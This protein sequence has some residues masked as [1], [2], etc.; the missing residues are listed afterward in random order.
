MVHSLREAGHAATV[1][2]T[3]HAALLGAR[4]CP[5]LILLDLGLPDI[6]GDEV[7]RRLKRQPDT[8]QIPVV[9][10]SGE[11][12]AAAIVGRNG[13]RG[14]VAI[15]QKPLLGAELCAVVDI[16][17]DAAR[18]GAEGGAG[19]ARRGTD[20]HYR[21]QA[22]LLY[23]LI[24]TASGPLVRQICHRVGADRARGTLS[25]AVEAPSWPEIIRRAKQE[26]LLEE[27]E[28]RSFLQRAAC[29]PAEPIA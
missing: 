27:T 22:E 18:T 11:P 20:A 9:I 14:P 23:R 3:G 10:V 8:A 25:R 13:A 21:E 29:Q 26:G 5:D 7:L 17:L 2:P 28:G 12:D 6:S 15:L 1:A 19:P 4:V 24:S 16:V